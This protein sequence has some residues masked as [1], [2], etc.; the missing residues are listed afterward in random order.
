MRSAGVGNP[1]A[2]ARLEGRESGFDGIGAPGRPWGLGAGRPLATGATGGPPSIPWDVLLGIQ[3]VT[4]VFNTVTIRH[5]LHLFVNRATRCMASGNTSPPRTPESRQR[6]SFAEVWLLPHRSSLF[7]FLYQAIEGWLLLWLTDRAHKLVKGCLSLVPR[8][9]A[10]P[11]PS[12]PSPPTSP[13]LP[14]T[15]LVVASASSPAASFDWVLYGAVRSVLYPFVVAVSHPFSIVRTV[16]LVKGE[17]LADGIRESFIAVMP[18]REASVYGRSYWAHVVSGLAD[19][20]LS[21][22]VYRA[23]LPLLQRHFPNLFPPPQPLVRLVQVDEM[24]ESR[25]ARKATKIR[26]NLAIASL[27]FFSGLEAQGCSSLCEVSH[28]GLVSCLRSVLD[29]EGFSGLYRGFRAHCVSLVAQSIWMAGVFGLSHLSRKM[30]SL[31]G[32]DEDDEDFLDD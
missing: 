2:A 11:A 27:R 7:M 17:L 15:A 13:L 32:L 24:L 4:G 8:L 22:L 5:R 23:S 26:R 9:S 16:F 12:P 10:S 14:P 29:D 18:S 30:D 25:Q 3:P 28:D 19:F 20:W 31:L 21:E 1:N 6:K